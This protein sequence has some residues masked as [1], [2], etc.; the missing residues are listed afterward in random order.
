ML[1]L[2]G[3]EVNRS[4]EFLRE[5]PWQHRVPCHISR[6]SS[7]FVFS[8]LYSHLNKHHLKPPN[9]N[10]YRIWMNCWKTSPSRHLGTHDIIRRIW[11][12]IIYLEL[13]FFWKKKINE[14]FSVIYQKI[15]FGKLNKMNY[16]YVSFQW[17]KPVLSAEYHLRVL[18]FRPKSGSIFTPFPP[19]L[20]HFSRAQTEFWIC[21]TVFYPLQIGKKIFK[22]KWYVHVQIDLTLPWNWAIFDDFEQKPDFYSGFH[23]Q[24]TLVYQNE[25]D[26]QN[27]R[28]KLHWITCCFLKNIFSRKLACGPPQPS[29]WKNSLRGP[30]GVNFREKICF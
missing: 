30:S 28:K 16:L 22:K 14:T 21:C 10:F 29:T 9:P 8:I 17:A 15:E 5:S 26:I 6:H 13:S 2:I 24:N 11:W 12:K 19:A 3:P 20:S 1:N 4:G 18:I 7:K 25:C 23:C 27:R